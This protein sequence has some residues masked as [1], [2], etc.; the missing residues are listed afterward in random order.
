MNGVTAETAAARR[1]MRRA[2]RPRPRAS[3]ARCAARSGGAGWPARVADVGHVAAPRRRP[4][5]PRRSGAPTTAARWRARRRR[6]AGGQRG[7]AADGVWPHATSGIGQQQ[8]SGRRAAARTPAA[9]RPRAAARRAAGVC[10]G[11]PAVARRGAPSPRPGCG[12]EPGVARLP[13]GVVRRK[14]VH[15]VRRASAGGGTARA[16]AAP[17]PRR[18]AGSSR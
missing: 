11:R 15:L 9:R 10:R 7:A 1:S 6:R 3:R 16:P 4:R 5:P 14:H 17:R 13:L 2:T 18:R 12:D 8:A